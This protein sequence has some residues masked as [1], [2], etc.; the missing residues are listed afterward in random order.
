MLVLWPAVIRFVYKCGHVLPHTTDG[1]TDGQTEGWTD[2]TTG[3]HIATFTYS[4][5]RKQKNNIP[6]SFYNIQPGNT[7]I[8]AEPI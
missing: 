8:T 5:G 4:T 2:I 1:E 6:Q 7:L 3:L